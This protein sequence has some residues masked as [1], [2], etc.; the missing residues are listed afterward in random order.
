MQI[1]DIKEQVKNKNRVSIFIGGSYAFSL[2]KS[3]LI[4]LGLKIGDSISSQQIT[5]YKKVSE[6]G[7]LRDMVYNWLAIRSRSS[8]E[9]DQYLKRKTNDTILQD[10]IKNILIEKGYQDDISFSEMW[11]RSRV[12]VKPISK[13]RLKQELLQKRV[14]LTIIE[15]ELNKSEIDELKACKLLI[16]KRGSRYKDKQK[17]MAFLARQGYSYEIIKTALLNEED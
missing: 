16:E 14:P 1:T 11:I 4:E 10:S 17:L 2:D 8:W 9:I 12:A 5:E 15:D 7:K 6:V 3:L 13:R